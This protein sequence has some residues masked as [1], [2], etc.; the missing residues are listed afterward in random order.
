MGWFSSL[1]YVVPIYLLYNT[2]HPVLWAL[3]IVNAIVNFWSYGVMHNY[4]VR[5]SLRGIKRLRENLAFD[6]TL[7]VEKERELDRLKLKSNPDAVPDWLA[8]INILST[9]VGLVG[10]IYG[11]WLLL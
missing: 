7:D 4:A 10:L 6:G 3:T 11:T 5:Q 9:L 2:G 8:G 1:I